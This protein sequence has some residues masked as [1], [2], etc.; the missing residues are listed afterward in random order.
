M[1]ILSRLIMVLFG[2]GMGIWVHAQTDSIQRSVADSIQEQKLLVADSNSKEM[3]RVLLKTR[4]KQNLKTY[5]DTKTLSRQKKKLI[6]LRNFAEKLESVLENAPDTHQIARMIKQTEHYY[7]MALTGIKRDSNTFA[8]S[9]N[10]AASELIMIELL[11]ELD[12]TM[13]M[14]DAEINTIDKMQMTFDSLATDTSIYNVP[15]DTVKFR[16][17]VVQLSA[18]SKQLMPFVR[19]M[20]TVE[21][22]LLKLREQV[23]GLSD[24]IK[25]AIEHINE[26]RSYQE[27]HVFQREIANLWED[28][29][30]TQNGLNDSVK[31]PFFR[32]RIMMLGFLRHNQSLLLFMALLY[33]GVVA[34]FYFMKHA[35]ISQHGDLTVAESNTVF[36][37]P[38]LS[39]LYVT[40]TIGQFFFVYPPFIFQ[41]VIWLVL[42]GISVFFLFRHTPLFERSNAIRWLLI[43]YPVPVFINLLL[44]PSDAERYA[45]AALALVATVLS[46]VY[47]KNNRQRLLTNKVVLLMFLLFII[48]EGG[49]F[50]AMCFG[51]FNLGKTLLTSAYFTVITAIFLI[52]TQRLVIQLLYF[53]VNE[54][55]G[56]SHFFEKIKKVQARISGIMNVMVYVGIVIVFFRNFYMYNTF[57]T[58]LREIIDAE[59]F[60]GHYSFT[61]YSMIVFVV[62][63]VVTFTVNR[64]LAFVFDNAGA[65]AEGGTGSK[66]GLK[67]WILLVKLGVIIT[68]FFL[69]FAAAGVPLNKLV[70]II[71][72]LGVGIGFGLQNLVNN[73]I[74]G[75]V[76]AFERP[77][78]VSDL[79]QI[80]SHM[81]RIKEIGMR[82]SKIENVDGSEM[83]VPNGDLLNQQIIN[84]T[85]SHNNRRIEIVIGLDYGTDIGRAK[86]LI[87]AMLLELDEV[88][89]TPAPSVFVS[90]F[91]DSDIQIK[92]LCWVSV[93]GFLLSRSNV[94][95]AIEKLF[96]END[97]VI[98]FPKLDITIGKEE[99][100]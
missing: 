58:W 79:V 39:L 31:N 27:G 56:V 48:C 29:H 21:Y 10:L 74:S 80:N 65:Q 19:K 78:E 17:V 33:A 4:L 81:G 22:E 87:E 91:K 60:I 55:D 24:R 26:A 8:V 40:L 7:V 15:D 99:V 72:S 64:L 37:Y 49:A 42:S 61:L 5:H 73:V 36:K 1:G 77:F 54:T 70:I 47:W 68:G 93:D 96:R 97:I 52:W 23:S 3:V 100:K 98:P 66:G 67:N 57:M 84:W 32:N 34:L 76:L 6:E 13:L 63:L 14:M 69:A 18:L 30:L 45:I 95:L 75:V 89:K 41:A 94:I 16:E 90:D 43:C 12:E 88:R 53:P 28:A 38:F 85:H 20:Y 9:R 62:T 92:V 25:Q 46:F 44:I 2:L 35:L 51:R 71:G 82:S 59:R 50:F 11:S 83:I 86:G